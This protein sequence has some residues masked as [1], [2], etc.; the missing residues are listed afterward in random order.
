MQNKVTW[1]LIVAVITLVGALAV[2][3]QSTRRVA[4]DLAALRQ[5]LAGAVAPQEQAERPRS[6]VSLIDNAGIIQ[7]LGALE[8]TVS[9][10]AR[11]SEYLMERGQLPLAANRVSDLQAKFADTTASD[12]DRLQALRVLRR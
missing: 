7:R 4:S 10:L 1:L 9:Q 11:N 5:E 2:Q 3:H 6:R 8:D 12:R